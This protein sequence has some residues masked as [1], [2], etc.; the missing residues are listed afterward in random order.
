[1]DTDDNPRVPMKAGFEISD[2]ELRKTR[3]SGDVKSSIDIIK[4]N[5]EFLMR[6][7]GET[8]KHR[9][10]WLIQLMTVSGA[11]F[12]GFTLT[13]NREDTATDIG[14]ILLFAVIFTGLVKVYLDNKNLVNFIQ[15]VSRKNL[16]SQL[17]LIS[18]L[19]LLEKQSL[20]KKEQS[21]MHQ[22][23][24]YLDSYVRETGLINED[25]SI[26][27]IYERSL[28]RKKFDLNYLLIA[29]FILSVLIIFFPDI[30][31]EKIDTI[32]NSVNSTL[33]NTFINNTSIPSNTPLPEINSNVST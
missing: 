13:L 14:L 20:T 27:N 7:Y 11:I 6:E 24:D 17:K 15:E 5:S 31:G 21:R 23:E 30:S 33:N 28:S 9:D 19:S 25:G 32:W 8:L 26:G 3:I 1:M 4:I 22:F 29:G 2:D 10:T 12:G 18:Y 16:D